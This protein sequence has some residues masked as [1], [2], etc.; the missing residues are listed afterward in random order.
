MAESVPHGGDA[1]S[2]RRLRV[3]ILPSCTQA[4]RPQ[5]GEEGGATQLPTDKHGGLN[6]CNSRSSLAAST[7]DANDGAGVFLV[8]DSTICDATSWCLFPIMGRESANW[9]NTPPLEILSRCG[10]PNLPVPGAEWRNPFR[11]DRTDQLGPR[12][13]RTSS[14]TNLRNSWTTQAGPPSRSSLPSLTRNEPTR[15]THTER[16]QLWGSSQPEETGR[17]FFAARRP[18]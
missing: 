12:G 9:P 18:Q 13:C 6:L 1:R 17:L 3:A 8:T 7:A 4:P 2:A 5:V 16:R 10:D 14:A 15:P 11:V